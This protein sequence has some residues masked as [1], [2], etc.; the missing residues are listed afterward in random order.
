M[1][2]I[3]YYQFIEKLDKEFEERKDDLV[4]EL[5]HL[6]QEILR[7]EYLC[8]SYTGERAVSYTH[9]ICFRCQNG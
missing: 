2:G 8:V 3:A 4:K 7:P 6:M 9:L 1:A 5:S